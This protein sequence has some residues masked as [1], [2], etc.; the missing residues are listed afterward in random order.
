[1]EATNEAVVVEVGSVG[2]DGN[3]GSVGKMGGRGGAPNS[4]ELGLTVE[5]ELGSDAHR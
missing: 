2:F 3:G 4:G 1:V 5:V